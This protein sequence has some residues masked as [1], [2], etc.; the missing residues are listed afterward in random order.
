MAA[1][2]VLVV[3]A[4]AADYCTRSGGTI[5]NLVQQG[6]RVH[7]LGPYLQSPRGVGRILEG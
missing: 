1:N 6:F 2:N 4:H 5:L 3:S 7:V